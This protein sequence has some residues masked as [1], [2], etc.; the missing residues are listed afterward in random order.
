MYLGCA[1]PDCGNGK[2]VGSKF[3]PRHLKTPFFEE[4]EINAYRRGIRDE[5][6]RIQ[7]L[8][9]ELVHKNPDLTRVLHAAILAPPKPR[10]RRT[11]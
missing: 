4:E 2:C 6:A 3:C 7:A 8:L 5:R 11:R 9:R 1:Y 10:R